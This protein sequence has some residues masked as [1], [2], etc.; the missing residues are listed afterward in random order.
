MTT[1]TNDV[2]NST[3]NREINIRSVFYKKPIKKDNYNL[4]ID[5]DDS[6]QE[7]RRQRLLNYQKKCRDSAVNAARDILDEIFSSDDEFEESHEVEKDKK[8]YLR[9]YK[10]QFVNKLMMSEWMLDVP[11]DL[12][13]NWSMVP[14]PKGQRNLLIAS[15][16]KTQAYNRRGEKLAEFKSA[17]PGGHPEQ[18]N[19]NCTILDCIWEGI[20]KTYYVLD[21]LAWSNQP[22]LDCDAEFRRYWI[23]S[24]FEETE[25][26]KLKNTYANQYPILSLPSIACSENL[27]QYFE[28]DLPFSS[29]DGLLFYH[30]E[31][32]YMHGNTPLV[33]WLKPFMLSEVLGISVPPPLSDKPLG[34]IDFKHHIISRTSK[35]KQH[36][37]TVNLSM[38]IA[39]PES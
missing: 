27:S 21:V 18:N 33:T 32:H 19:K 4:D 35:Q 16:G 17:L 5:Y 12:L 38:D 6:P 2:M 26:L 13:E 7:V 3:E 30:R 25:A 11:E 8:K 29:L 31:G 36:V 9:K 20:N 22:L 24:K 14:C 39:D 34:Y 1:G 28:N 37:N 23:K 10:K 15:R